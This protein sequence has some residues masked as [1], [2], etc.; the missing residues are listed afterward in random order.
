MISCG[1]SVTVEYTP[2]ISIFIKAAEANTNLKH[3]LI[4]SVFGVYLGMKFALQ[5]PT[6]MMIVVCLSA[7]RLSHTHY[8][9]TT[10][11]YVAALLPIGRKKVIAVLS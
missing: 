6:V 5:D 7:C 2:F 11:P 8:Y 3:Y 1:V 10:I 9:A 4:C